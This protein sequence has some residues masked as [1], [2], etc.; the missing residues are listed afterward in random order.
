[1]RVA[2]LAAIALLSAPATA[3]DPV[4]TDQTA[5]ATTKVKV[6][7][8]CRAPNQTGSRLGNNKVCK[9]QDEWDAEARQMQQE[10]GKGVNNAG[11]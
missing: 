8:V 7:K 5:P 9:T 4:T 11:G 6:K 1:M 10:N 2:I 3:A